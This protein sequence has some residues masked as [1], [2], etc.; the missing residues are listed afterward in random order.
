MIW[1][2]QR[3]RIRIQRDTDLSVHLLDGDPAHAFDDV[4]VHELAFLADEPPFWVGCRLKVRRREEEFCR[5]ATVVWAS[6]LQWLEQGSPALCQNSCL[7]GGLVFIVAPAAYRCRCLCPISGGFRALL[8]EFVLQTPGCGC[9]QLTELRSQCIAMNSH[10]Q[11]VF[12]SSLFK[13]KNL[14]RQDHHN[15]IIFIFNY[16]FLHDKLKDEYIPMQENSFAE[17]HT[18]KNQQE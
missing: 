2:L 11:K 18:H 16:C 14:A 9:W 3:L 1:L 6:R 7:G 5:R 4:Y 12:F 17:I 8:L 13:R 10:I 15:R